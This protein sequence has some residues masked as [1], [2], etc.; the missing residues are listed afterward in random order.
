MEEGEIRVPNLARPNSKLVARVP[1]RTTLTHH[2]SLR[3]FLWRRPPTIEPCRASAVSSMLS[4]SSSILWPSS[5]RTVSSPGVRPIPSYRYFPLHPQ[6]D[7]H[8]SSIFLSVLCLGIVGWSTV[9]T[10]NPTAGF[11]QP[12]DQ[13]GGVAG[14][15]QDIGV[16]GRLIN[17]IGA[18][19]T[20]MRSMYTILFI[21]ESGRKMN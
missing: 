1:L 4:S 20:L 16:K 5:A 9:P 3:P 15:V 12:Y 7:T 10:Q 14:G 19:R 2:F 17:L 13:Y 11:Q 18:V 21:H 8:P 6:P